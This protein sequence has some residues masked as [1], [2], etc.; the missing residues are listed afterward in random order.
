MTHHN[1]PAGP[2]SARMSIAGNGMNLYGIPRVVIAEPGEATIR[3]AVAPSG[4]PVDITTA[5]LEW[6]DDLESAIQ[7]AR[8]QGIVE[9]GMAARA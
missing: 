1:S 9:A 3:L 4:A 2:P 8:A 6:L 5:S 7:V